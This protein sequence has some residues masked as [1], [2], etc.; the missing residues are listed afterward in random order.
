[1]IRKTQITL[2]IEVRFEDEETTTEMVASDLAWNLIKEFGEDNDWN[3]ER[4]DK[5]VVLNT[6]AVLS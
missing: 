5:L 4:D 6:Q 2:T 3:A 1:M